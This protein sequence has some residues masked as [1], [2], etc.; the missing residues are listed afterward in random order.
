MK[1][2]QI[3]CFFPLHQCIAQSTQTLFAFLPPPD[4]FSLF[5]FMIASLKMKMRGCIFRQKQSVF[6]K[7]DAANPIRRKLYEY[8]TR[9]KTSAIPAEKPSIYTG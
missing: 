5:E 9:C 8:Y 6:K 3:P 1:Y 4:Y 2:Q 7:E